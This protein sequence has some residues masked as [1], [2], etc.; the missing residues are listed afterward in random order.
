MLLRAL[1]VRPP[2][3]AAPSGR[4][5]SSA[6]PTP[7]KEEEGSPAS[8]VAAK[9]KQALAE[10]PTKLKR[11][12]SLTQALITSSLAPPPRTLSGEPGKLKAG[13][14]SFSRLQVSPHLVKRSAVVPP[15]NLQALVTN[16]FNSAVEQIK[17]LPSKTFGLLKSLG[18][19]TINFAKEPRVKLSG[20][21][22]SIKHEAGHYWTGFKVLGVEV[23]TSVKLLSARLRGVELTRRQSQ[24]L[25]RT[26]TDLLRMGP[27]LVFVIVPFMEFAL[28]VFLR[29]FPNMLPSPFI[30]ED[31]KKTNIKN[32][33]QLRLEMAS[34]MQEMVVEMGKK[35]VSAQEG[36]QA[37]DTVKALVDF[38]EASR[39]AEPINPDSFSVLL[40]TFSDD[41]LTMER[42]TREK[43]Q[44]LC[45]FMGV[46]TIGSNEFLRYSLLA[47]LR[48]IREDDIQISWEGVENLTLTELKQCAVARGMQAESDDKSYYQ[49]KLK[50]WIELSVDRNVSPAMLILSQAFAV[51][52][53]TQLGQHR[54]QQSILSDVVTGLA[55]ELV[56]NTIVSKLDSVEHPKGDLAQVKLDSLRRENELIEKESTQDAHTETE[57][58]LEVD[59]SDEA[60]AAA[61]AKLGEGGDKPKH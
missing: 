28:P 9:L 42:M 54:R 52:G 47:R 17:F 55:P 57:K 40:E 12:S 1:R 50:R 19:F 13:S 29:L 7:K 56:Q 35:K 49:Q 33:S 10:K 39:N 53:P 27:F 44:M 37:E 25:N 48:T 21:W 15:Q 60:A 16:K 46:S 34:F 24:Q 18:R 45:R 61:R 58:P 26:F 4:C 8:D 51:S 14:I 3:A 6:S 30:Q 31:Q 41:E 22:H 5:F 2:P 23:K 43:L 32:I 38:V 20:M 59:M 36:K 11:E